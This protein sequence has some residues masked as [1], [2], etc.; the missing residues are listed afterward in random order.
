MYNLLVIAMI[1]HG[2]LSTINKQKKP[3]LRNL[4]EY[5]LYLNRKFMQSQNS[6]ERAVR[7]AKMSLCDILL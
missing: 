1:N 5:A 2:Y 7:V 4:N 3:M 6:H